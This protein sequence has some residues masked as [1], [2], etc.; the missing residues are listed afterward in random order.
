MRSSAISTASKRVRVGAMPE[1][2]WFYISWTA[3]ASGAVQQQYQIVQTPE[4]RMI[5]WDISRRSHHPLVNSSAFERAGMTGDSSGHWGTSLV[6]D[7]TNFTDSDS[8]PRALGESALI[9]RLL[10]RVLRTPFCTALRS[11]KAE[12]LLE[13]RYCGVSSW[14]RRSGCTK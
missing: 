9:E 2:R 5:L 1:L 6:V 10:P 11:T 14:R 7:T 8:V 4:S 12:H 3:E 13:E